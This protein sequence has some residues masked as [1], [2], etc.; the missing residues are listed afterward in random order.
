M[1]NGKF[2]SHLSAPDTPPQALIARKLSDY[3]VELSWEE[4]LE[5]NSDILYYAVRVW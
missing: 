1:T 3:Q 5:A 2:L 4:P